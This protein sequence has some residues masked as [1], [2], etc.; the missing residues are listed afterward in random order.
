MQATQW[1]GREAHTER[2]VQRWFEVCIQEIKSRRSVGCTFAIFSTTQRCHPAPA[3]WVGAIQRLSADTLQSANE[4]W[5]SVI[6]S[7]HGMQRFWKNF[8]PKMEKIQWC[9]PSQLWTRSLFLYILTAAWQL[10][11]KRLRASTSKILVHGYFF[12]VLNFLFA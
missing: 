1:P 12:L 7:C 5:T 11:S 8:S 6:L 9:H 10:L 3:W 2:L 4:S